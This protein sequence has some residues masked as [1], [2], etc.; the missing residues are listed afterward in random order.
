MEQAGPTTETLRARAED[1]ARGRTA[2]HP[3]PPQSL[4]EMQRTLHE[5]QVHQIELEMQN[6]QLRTAQIA[7]DAE[8]G[9]Y[10]DLYDLAPVGYC[11]ANPSGLILQANLKAATLLGLSRGALIRLPLSRFVRISIIFASNRCGKVRSRRNASCNW[12]R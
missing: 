6:D 5:L 10:F 2:L 8:R 4:D 7:L 12:P 11:T 1:V 9:R 3:S